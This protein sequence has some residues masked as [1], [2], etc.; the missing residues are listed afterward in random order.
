M[1]TGPY[2]SLGLLGTL[3]SNLPFDLHSLNLKTEIQNAGKK[4]I[5]G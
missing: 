1:D 5:C 4:T 3:A 2:A